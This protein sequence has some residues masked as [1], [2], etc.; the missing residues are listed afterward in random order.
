M[1]KKIVGIGIG[2]LLLIA[3]VVW[4]KVTWVERQVKAIVE[5]MEE[6]CEVAA[7][8]PKGLDLAGRVNRFGKLFAQE[9]EVDLKKDSVLSEHLNR[10][11]QND[12]LQQLFGST[13]MMTKSL[14]MDFDYDSV[15][16]VGEVIQA[17]TDLDFKL[18]IMTGTYAES[19]EAVV[20]L[21][22]AKDGKWKVFKITEK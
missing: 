1:D 15:E 4:W 18:V 2:A 3:W 11:V 9:L 8:P 16:K 13:L 12:Q 5:E 6:V 22:K 19:M 20:E 7:G 17:E 10:A 21:K 14:S